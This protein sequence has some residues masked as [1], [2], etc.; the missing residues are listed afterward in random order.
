MIRF[1]YKYK[2]SLYIIDFILFIIR[3]KDFHTLKNI[4]LSIIINI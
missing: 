1:N 4:Y 3:N 2:E